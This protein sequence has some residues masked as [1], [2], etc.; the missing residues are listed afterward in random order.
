[1]AW[2]SRSS[3]RIPAEE[4][5]TTADTAIVAAR[6]S[7]ALNVSLWIG[8]VILLS[9]LVGGF[10][11]A[12][13]PVDQQAAQMT[14][15][16]DIPAALLRFIGVVEMLGAIGVV[17]PALTRIKPW[18][19]PLAAAGLAAIMLLALVFH[20]AR[21]GVAMMGPNIVLGGMAAFVA[22]GRFRKAPIPPRR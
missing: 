10:L 2:V 14:C 6:P 16:G 8:Q 1:M 3:Y 15:T 13:V 7:R 4:G 9:F 18:L 20:L 22:W 17:L 12:T 5:M 21:G 11:K 19:T